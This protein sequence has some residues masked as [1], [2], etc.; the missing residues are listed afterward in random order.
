MAYL[1]AKDFDLII[2]ADNLAQVISSDTSIRI[3]AERVAKEEVEFYLSSKFDLTKEFTNTAVFS[4]A[5]TYKAKNRVYLDG[6]AWSAS[7]TYALNNI[8]SVGGNV[9]YCIQA[10]LNQSPTT[11]TAYW[12]LIGVQYDL[13]Y[14]TLPYDEFDYLDNYI[15]GDQVW[16]K[17]KV[18]TCLMP[19]ITYSHDEILQYNSYAD[20]PVRNVFPDDETYGAIHWG[21]GVAY[22]VAPGTLPTDT[23]KWTEGDNRSQLILENML[24]IAL[25]KAL[26]RIAPRNTPVYRKDNFT[27]AIEWLKEAKNGEGKPNIPVIQPRSGTRLRYGGNTKNINHY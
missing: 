23:T 5:T 3:F 26:P 15:V 22:S 8:V 19:S 16:W 6:T 13:Y 9:Y 11:A 25:Y 18:Y 7:T 27:N 14:V 20:V 1:R 12:T 24:H 21:A 10:G 4:L 17:D 2:M